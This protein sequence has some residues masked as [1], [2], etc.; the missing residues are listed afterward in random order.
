LTE[1]MPAI[2]GGAGPKVTIREFKQEDLD[3]VIMINKVCL[4]ENYSSSF[5]LEHFFE[6]PK[7][8]IVAEADGKIIGYNMCR[9]EFGVSYI[10]TAF[11]KKG[12][13]ISIAVLDDYRG[14]GIGNQLMVVG[15]QRVKEAGASEMYLEVRVS[16]TNAISL[17]RRLGFRAVKILEGYY[18][19]G[20]SA[21]LMAID[22]SKAG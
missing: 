1:S 11:A 12:H 16:N 9:V 18:R 19:D 20:E 3:A 6:N 15:M 21:Y 7:C 4:P 5:F 8:F 13:V 10:R 2:K 17:Y 22:L 14:R